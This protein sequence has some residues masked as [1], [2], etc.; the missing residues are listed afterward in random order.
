MGIT[1]LSGL[2]VAG[3]PTM[4]VGGMPFLTG[5]WYFVDA[6][7]G[8]DGNT[9][10]ADD[11]M[12][13]I[14]AAYAKCV[15]G[16]NDVVVLV[17]HPTTADNAVGTHRLTSQLVWAKSATH[18]I[19]ICAPTTI[20]QRARISHPTTDTTNTA[21]LLKITAS[22]CYFSNF[23]IFQGVGQAATAEKLCQITGSR[24]YFENVAFQGIGSSVGG[25]VAAGYSLYL[26]GAEENTFVGCQIGVDT[27]ARTAA[28]FSVLFAGAAKR[29]LFKGCIFPMLATAT[30]PF[31]ISCATSGGVD[32]FNLFQ[33][34]LFHNAVN[35]TGTSIDAVVQ[36]HATQG[37]TTIMDNCTSVGADDWTPTDT[38]VVRILG[39]VSNGDTSGM[40]V[41]ADAT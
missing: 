35:S 27:V 5:T 26:N 29:N 2:Q 15:E 8:S 38:G 30:S 21:D 3:V 12:A 33:Q 9:G 20:G 24:N 13:T 11:P 40:G 31:F 36:F 6:V 32:R 41:S 34:C 37:G 22:G 7:Y 10:A 14:A 39:P 1:H 23:S 19:G 18:M 25:T 28:N 17:S 16:K 4:G